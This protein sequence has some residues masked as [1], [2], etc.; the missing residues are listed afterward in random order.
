MNML[1]WF[2][3]IAGVWFI[4]QI[5]YFY[6]GIK[7]YRDT[8]AWYRWLSDILRVTAVTAMGWWIYTFVTD[9]AH[10]MDEIY[11]TLMQ[12]VDVLNGHS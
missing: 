7:L 9:T 10:G 11:K 6:E 3:V 2:R 8:T 12:V 4:S 1:D 5:L